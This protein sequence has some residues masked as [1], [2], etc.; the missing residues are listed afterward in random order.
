MESKYRHRYLLLKISEFIV[1]NNIV[2]NCFVESGVKQG[3]AS[4]VM[5]KALNRKGYLFDTWTNFPHFSKFDAHSMKRRSRL[6]KRV[7]G[8]KD[9]YQE[10]VDNLRKNKVFG[11]CALIRGDICKTIPKFV[12][13]YKP[14]LFISLIHSDSDLHEPT[15]VT[16]NE[17][18]PFLVDG[19]M[20]LVHDYKTKQWPGIER[21]VD[22]FLKD[23]SN[24]HFAQIGPEV[25]ASCLIMRDDTEQYKKG[26]SGIVAQVKIKFPPKKKK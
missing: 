6:K 7:K 19:G 4:V 5:A 14:N 20:I 11:S 3:S 21:S 2:G 8:G 9:T 16:L 13:N 18:W 22:K 15:K 25:T 10:C 1:S 12:E 24:I 23:K 26:F 17:L